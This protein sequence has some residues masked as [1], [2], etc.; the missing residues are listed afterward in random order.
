VEYQMMP[1]KSRIE[2]HPS[3]PNADVA[4]FFLLT[5]L[6]SWLLWG[7][8]ARSGKKAAEFPPPLVVGGGFGPSLVALGLVGL[9]ASPQ[10]RREFRRAITELKRIRPAWYV[11]LAMLPVMPF[12]VPVLLRPP[13]HRGLR[14]SAR[15]VLSAAASGLVSGVAEE[16]GWRGY[17][18]GRLQ[19]SR[20][21]LASSLAIGIPWALWHLPL[22]F[23][24]GMWQY[25][26]RH[27][28]MQAFLFF[29]SIVAQSV[30]MG[31]VYNH[32]RRSTVSAI[33]FHALADIAGILISLDDSDA[34]R[35]VEVGFFAAMACAVMLDPQSRRIPRKPDGPIGP[36]AALS[37]AQ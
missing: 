10:E 1:G 36:G 29:P 17:A 20:T 6:W 26:V 12:L 37:P 22:Y 9:R 5:F 25:Q 2:G 24:P 4:R 16:L 7:Q 34:E 28:K 8:V 14:L 3:D 15:T 13:G 11:V 31:W 21:P 35:A 32:A 23:T 19:A 18:Q 33:L 30:L 27:R